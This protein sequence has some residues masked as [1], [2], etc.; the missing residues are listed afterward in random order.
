MN[1][2]VSAFIVEYLQTMHIHCRMHPLEE[3]DFS[4]LDLGLRTEILGMGAVD[5]AHWFP[6]EGILV[7][8][9]D[10]FL[11]AYSLFVDP[12]EKVRYCVGPYL[13]NELD[14]KEILEM[15]SLENI[16]MEAYKELKEYYYA[17]PL[18]TEKGWLY[19]LLHQWVDGM[20]EQDVRIEHQKHSHKRNK[21]SQPTY[22]IAND[23][24]V[25]MRILEERYAYETELLLAVQHGNYQKMY[26]LLESGSMVRLPK[27]VED[28][29]QESK[30]RMIVINTLMRRAVY[31][32]GVHPLHIDTLS[33]QHAV[34]INQMS[35]P[36]LVEGLAIQ[37]VTS[38]FTL[39][40][41]HSLARYSKPIQTIIAT[42]D[43]SLTADLR[44][45]TFASQMYLNASY[46]SALFKKEVGLTLT[47][48]VNSKRLEYSE[49]LLSTTSL[50][51][52]EVAM[53]CGI[54]DLHY[55]TRLFKK[56]YAITP[57]AY[58]KQQRAN[59]A[60]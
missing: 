50:S 43:A 22:Q 53:Q 17:L 20:N 13:R 48:Y 58:R 40:K 7:H 57:S 51:I 21:Q 18:L 55:F 46:L 44:L 3:L 29:L 41:A 10:R 26:D 33:N 38:Y 27:R 60:K 19:S 56:T 16:P 6:K 1:P 25:S 47:E 23:P 28:P 59:Q 4:L 2:S 54:Q 45:Q 37:M 31:Q 42:I 8:M 32:G 39:V 36:S 35:D 15:M 5:E 49:T 34:L 30:H 52:Q 14:E 12:I 24:I 9:Q 11:C